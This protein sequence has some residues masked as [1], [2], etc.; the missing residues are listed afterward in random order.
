MDDDCRGVDELQPARSCTLRRSCSASPGW[1]RNSRHRAGDSGPDRAHEAP[2]VQLS[3]GN[4]G[5]TIKLPQNRLEQPETA[6]ARREAASAK[7]R[8]E[9]GRESWW[10]R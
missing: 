7:A 3:P 10:E 4:A 2:P 1:P 8:I 5:N 6:F 9:I